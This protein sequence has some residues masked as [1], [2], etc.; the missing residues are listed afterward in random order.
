MSEFW[1]VLFNFH[2]KAYVD[3]VRINIIII[4]QQ[5]LK[6]QLF[7]VSLGWVGNF[8]L[9]VYVLENPLKFKLKET[10]YVF[11]KVLIKSSRTDQ[12]SNFF[13]TFSFASL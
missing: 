3:T 10:R 8:F 6:V 2:E 11:S 13:F 9:S 5:N 4:T 12:L 1:L 7:H